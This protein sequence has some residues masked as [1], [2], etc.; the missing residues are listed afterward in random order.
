MCAISGS[1]TLDKAFRL[2]T[3]GLERGH[4]GSGLFALTKE[5]GYIYKQEKPFT[6]DDIHRWVDDKN[7]IVYWAFHSRAPTNV[8]HSEWSYEKTHPFRYKGYIVAHNGI[9]DNFKSFVESDKFEIDS[10]IIPYHLFENDGNIK[11]VYE[12]YTGLL[13]S[14]IY[15]LNKHKF[16]IV[17]G[18]SSLFKDETSFSSLNFKNSTQVN[19]DGIIFELTENYVL[20]QRDIFNYSNPYFIL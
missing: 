1:T 10:S 4:Y 19:D 11:T 16:Y 5:V 13:T 6:I 2:Y 12:Q 7:E 20:E 3:E 14:W 18:G 8:I 15:D 17:K 9:I